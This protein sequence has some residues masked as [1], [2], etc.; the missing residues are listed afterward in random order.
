MKESLMVYPGVMFK[1]FNS[2]WYGMSRDKR[3]RNQPH[4][5]FQLNTSMGRDSPSGSGPYQLIWEYR[6]IEGVV[7]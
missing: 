5:A 7:K 6:G 2:L 3:E 4:G 1:T